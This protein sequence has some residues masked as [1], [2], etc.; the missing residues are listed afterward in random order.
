M[1]SAPEWLRIFTELHT[2][3]GNDDFLYNIRPKSIDLAASK[4]GAV[5]I[6]LNNGIRGPEVLITLRS[7]ELRAHSGQPSFPGGA[8]EVDESAR[9]AALRESEEEVGIRR[10]S[11][12]VLSELPDLFIPPS[13][14]L[15]TPILGYWR[16]PHE[17]ALEGSS[18]VVRT[19][20]IPL[21]ELADPTNRIMLR[22]RSG[23]RG[24]AFDVADMR[25][26]GFTAGILDRLI[27]HAGFEQEWNRENTVELEL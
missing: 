3:L 7:E 6:L 19:E 17:F 8:L 5:L 4:R 16:E 23:Y 1:V 15:V 9:D 27:Y 21:E 14:F 26:W 11:I 25:I 24:P 2:Q 22:H 20:F 12:E 18:E 13:N 10:E